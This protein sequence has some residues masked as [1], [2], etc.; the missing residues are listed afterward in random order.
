MHKS[1][2]TEARRIHAHI[3]H[4]VSPEQAPYN[5]ALALQNVA[6]I[7][8]MIGGNA[9]DISSKL[10]ET[11]VIFNTME[12][13]TGILFADIIQADLELREGECCT[14]EV[15][16]R[17]MLELAWRTNDEHAAFCLQ[18]LGDVGLWHPEDID[19]TFKWSIIFLGHALQ[20]KSKL[21]IH[22]ALR[23]LGNMFRTEGD[24]DTAHS[25]FAM[26]IHLGRASCM[27]RLGDIAGERGDLRLAVE[28]W[29]T[30]RP[31]FEK[32]LQTKGMHE[33]DKLIENVG[34]DL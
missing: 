28:L 15:A 34:L 9:D 16:F 2:Y 30:A 17:E 20:S 4:E 1:E 31:L 19:W 5:Y 33:I 6:S 10:D 11:R 24:Q 22:Q 29:T 12:H 8:V 3:A 32:S 18:R 27:L 23:C 7:D 26:D 13:P 21:E 25:L 14:G